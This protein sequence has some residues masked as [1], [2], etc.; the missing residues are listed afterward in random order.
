MKTNQGRKIAYGVGVIAIFMFSACSNKS[1]GGSD[2]VKLTGAAGGGDQLLA[3]SPAP[4]FD[5]ELYDGGAMVYKQSTGVGVLQMQTGKSYNL[6]V[7]SNASPSL[8]LQFKQN[9]LPVG[10]L[11]PLHLGGNLVTAPNTG[12][13]TMAITAVGDTGSVGQQDYS[14]GVYCADAVISVNPGQIAVSNVD[15]N[16][17]RYSAPGIETKDGGVMSGGDEPDCSWD[18]NGDGIRDKDFAPCS[19]PVNAYSNHVGLRNINVFVRD[20]VC[21]MVNKATAA[22]TLVDPN[23]APTGPDSF[24]RGDIAAVPASVDPRLNLQH[25]SM[26]PAA[27]AGVPDPMPVQCS[28]SRSNGKGSFT[29][30]GQIKYAMGTSQMH[31]LGITMSNII[32]NVDVN[33]VGATGNLDTS[34]AVV[35]KVAF[36]TDENPDSA[37]KLRFEGGASFCTASMTALYEVIAGVPCAGGQT[38]TGNK[39]DV[40]G[41]GT[42]QCVNLPSNPSS[43]LKINVT[44]GSFFCEPRF[45]DSC[46]G[47]SGGSGGG[48]PPI[49]L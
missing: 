46:I 1:T 24:I 48:I 26:N 40:R 16:M 33:S 36:N 45:V 13:Y 37:S 19:T 43:G 49:T 10:A 15:K 29:V 18:F 41:Y 6:V 34:V 3:V 12:S 31:G 7:N 4:T 14:I 27:G 20:K 22:K 11:I 23:P 8:S 44:N 9:Q 32:D 47:G 5:I 42:F 38:G 39:I 35:N 28:Y 2:T 25:V 17:Y 21:L 30:R